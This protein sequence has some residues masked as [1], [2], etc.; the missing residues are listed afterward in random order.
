[1]DSDA[2]VRWGLVPIVAA[3]AAATAALLLRLPALG[4]AGS[5]A[6]C[7]ASCAAG[8]LAVFA[9]TLPIGEVG[10]WA[11]AAL[12]AVVSA[13]L[14]PLWKERGLLSLAVGG[15]VAALPHV[16]AIRAANSL[17]REA[18]PLAVVAN[19]LSRGSDPIVGLLLGSAVDEELA[20]AIGR[21][22]A[23]PFSPRLVP[24]VAARSETAAGSWLRRLPVALRELSGTQCDPVPG[25]QEPLRE[26]SDVEASVD[27]SAGREQPFRIRWPR[28]VSEQAGAQCFVLTPF[29]SVE[30]S[31]DERG[32]AQ[33]DQ[34][35]TARMRRWIGAMPP[36]GRILIVAVPPSAADPPGW[37]S[38]VP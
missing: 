26:L 33:F 22:L 1:M 8:G 14:A 10:L 36:G 28:A 17:A 24:V 35:V 6:A 31:F 19:S 34:D 2:V 29:G 32:L 9:A 13:A 20:M 18:A 38:I 7:V 3:C 27:R 12:S 16:V 37:I 5:F 11:C 4:A 25:S 30:G 15:V 23:P 21:R